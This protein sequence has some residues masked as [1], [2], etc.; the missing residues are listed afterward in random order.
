VLRSP[1]L[2]AGETARQVR[3]SGV[4]KWRGAIVYVS[5][6][7]IGEPVGLAETDDGR[8]SVRYGPILLGFIDHRSDRLKRPRKGADGL[9]D[10]A[11][12][13]PQGPQPQQQQPSGT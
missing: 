10:N 5:G 7:L 11:E 12:R 1:G 4:I 2:A 9:V 13:C 6:A 8:W 3:R